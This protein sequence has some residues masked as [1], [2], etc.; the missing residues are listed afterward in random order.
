M[1]WVHSQVSTFCRLHNRAEFGYVAVTTCCCLGSMRS[2]QAGCLHL[3]VQID[4]GGMSAGLASF[5]GFTVT[6]FKLCLFD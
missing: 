1:H 5:A 3:W 4:T 2:G 6:C